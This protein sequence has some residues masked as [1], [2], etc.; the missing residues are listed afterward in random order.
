MTTTVNAEAP[1][2]VEAETDTQNEET[3][4]D[5]AKRGRERDRDFSTVV[6]R[7][8]ILAAFINEHS[9]LDPITPNQL[10]AVQLLSEDYR[11]SPE[12][13]E[14]RKKREA[15]RQAE[16]A[17]FAGLDEDEK[18]ELKAANRK[19]KQLAEVEARREEL[20]AKARAIR[21]SAEAS[22]EDL[23]STV[24]SETASGEQE[25]GKRRIGAGSRRK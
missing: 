24:E 11:N 18:K 25:P 20:L 21:E 23:A 17:E 3:V 1:A 10:K 6:E 16:E 4:T 9:K 8:K 12:Q 5:S 15:E 13:V 19:A 7:H 14:A 22:G 2:E